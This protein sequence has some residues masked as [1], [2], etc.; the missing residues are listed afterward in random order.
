[1][2]RQTVC[3]L[4]LGIVCAGTVLAQAPAMQPWAPVIGS[5]PG[6]GQLPLR[7]PYHHDFAA[8]AGMQQQ[9]F[10]Y[11]NGYY[12]N[13]LANSGGQQGYGQQGFGQQGGGCPQCQYGQAC[14]QGGCPSCGHGQGCP[15][16]LHSY[17]YN[18]PKNMVYPSN[19]Q[20]PAGL[21]QYPY[22]TFRGPTDFFMK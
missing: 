3:G 11:Q 12:N 1:M 13:V 21:V 20:L 4:A 14:P 22:Y 2:I 18:W 5:A 17:K 7:P 6:Y 8:R 9:N 16:H 10:G 15:Q 19:N